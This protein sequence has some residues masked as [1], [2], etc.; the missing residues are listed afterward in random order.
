MVH[1][2]NFPGYLKLDKVEAAR[3]CLATVVDKNITRPPQDN[4]RRIGA[5]TYEIYLTT[6]I[7]L[8]ETV[9]A[10]LE[11]KNISVSSETKILD[12]GCGVGRVALPLLLR[13]PVQ[14]DACDV[15]ES[16]INFLKANAN[17]LNA[18]VS[19]YSPPL[20]L[21][22]NYFDAVYAFSVFSHLPANVENIWLKELARIT[23]PGAALILST[24]GQ[25]Y[26]EF[27]RKN[28][29]FRNITW[30]RIEKEGFV[31][32]ENKNHKDDPTR[33][34]GVTDAY[35]LSFHHP[36]YIIRTW[37]EYFSEVEIIQ[38]APNGGQDIVV[39]TR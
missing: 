31:F 9:K 23:K 1:Y 30:K 7:R 17:G 37:G 2:D 14:L 29:N 33:W 5:P 22:D 13:G 21:D 19:N 3:N 20:P 34:P 24:C 38:A 32:Q 26:L 10:I 39:C 16:A 4:L 27:H 11:Y 6:G 35:G 18:F 15:D 36:G 25:L 28:G 8:A 12:W